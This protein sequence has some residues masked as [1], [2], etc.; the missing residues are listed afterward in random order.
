MVK[1]KTQQHHRPSALISFLNQDL[2]FVVLFELGLLLFSLYLVTP[3]LTFGFEY[4]LITSN[5]SYVSLSSLPLFMFNP[6][7]WM[8][9]GL[10]FAILSAVLLFHDFFINLDLRQPN[11]MPIPKIKLLILVNFKTSSLFLKTQTIHV[12]ICMASVDLLQYS[13]HYP[14]HSNSSLYKICDE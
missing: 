14:Y 6:L 13:T 10:V 12:G 3:I 8:T 1:K 9:L 4:A 11:Q 2:V 5:L 7:T